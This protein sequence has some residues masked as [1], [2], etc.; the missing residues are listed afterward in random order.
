[1]LS[2]VQLVEAFAPSPKPVVALFLNPG[3]AVVLALQRL[4]GGLSLFAGIQSSSRIA[5][6]VPRVNVNYVSPVR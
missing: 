6:Y 4:D 2:R 3:D 5:R 1:M